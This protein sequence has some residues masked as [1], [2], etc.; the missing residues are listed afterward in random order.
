MMMTPPPRLPNILKDEQV[1]QL[2]E[3]Y[4]PLKALYLPK[5]PATELCR[6]WAFFQYLDESVSDAAILGLDGL[7]VGDNKLQ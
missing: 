5:D 4:G 6:G 2:F 7:Q 1:K 3:S